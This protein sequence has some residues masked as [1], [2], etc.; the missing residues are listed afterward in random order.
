MNRTIMNVIVGAVLLVVFVSVVL[1]LNRSRA[2]YDAAVVLEALNLG[3]LK[4]TGDCDSSVDNEESGE[5]WNRTHPGSK[6]R[7]RVDGKCPRDTVPV[8]ARHGVWKDFCITKKAKKA[9]DYKKKNPGSIFEQKPGK[10]CPR[11]LV[12]VPK[13]KHKGKCVN[14]NKKAL[15]KYKYWGWGGNEGLRCLYNDNTGCNTVWVDGQLVAI[16]D[17][18]AARK[19]ADE[20]LMR[21]YPYW[22]WDANEGVR[23]LNKDNTGCN[24][25]WENGRLVEGAW[26]PSAASPAAAPEDQKEDERGYNFR[27]N[28]PNWGSGKAW[29]DKGFLDRVNTI[30]DVLDAY[31]PSIK[32]TDYIHAW[33][34]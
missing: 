31:S 10:N 15:R 5:E 21:K 32:S 6:F 14:L 20:A 29:K 26:K 12:K 9:E 30:Q 34:T 3:Y 2:K 22:G 4:G 18:D 17:A 7:A 13:G 24:T 33:G 16:S 19:A 8:D 27:E 1:W 28:R 25:H 23:C 11:G